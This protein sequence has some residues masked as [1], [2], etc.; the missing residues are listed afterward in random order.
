MPCEHPMQCHGKPALGVHVLIEIK[1][2]QTVAG[3]DDANVMMNHGD[4]S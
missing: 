3:H 1:G 2:Q 4:E